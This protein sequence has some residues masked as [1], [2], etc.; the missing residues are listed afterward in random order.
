MKFQ[1]VLA[2]AM[3]LAP[4]GTS[5]PAERVENVQNVVS[6]GPVQNGYEVS[7]VLDDG[8]QI[9]LKVAPAEAVKIVDGLSKPLGE[10]SQKQ[11]IVAIVQG[12]S[13]DADKAHQLI[14]LLPRSKDGALQ[15]LAIP[16]SAA[17]TLISAIQKAATTAKGTTTPTK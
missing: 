11:Q 7:A 14:V 3:V 12:V 13:I 6:A 4:A 9:V 8:E 2:L 5:S 1:I 10:G 16:V 15:P 17:D